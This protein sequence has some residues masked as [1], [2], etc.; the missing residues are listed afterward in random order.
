[1]TVE[2]FR[3]EMF[4]EVIAHNTQKGDT[5]ALRFKDDP[6]RYVGIPV[7]D[8]SAS[9]DDEFNFKIFEPEENKGLVKRSIE[10]IEWMDKA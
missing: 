8:S 10:E 5:F 4:Y 2:G 3:S 7:L 9:E 1:M 6:I